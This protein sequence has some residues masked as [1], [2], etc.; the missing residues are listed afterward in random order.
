MDCNI[1]AIR[2]AQ[3]LKRGQERYDAMA[4]REWDDAELSF[5]GAIGCAH[6]DLEATP[7]VVAE[8]LMRE[9]DD[10]VAPLQAHALASTL[11]QGERDLCVPELLAVL[12]GSYDKA[13]LRALYELRAKFERAHIDDIYAGARALLGFQRQQRLALD[14]RGEA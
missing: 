2:E 11:M 14:D 9:C 12:M 7:Y 6:E 10:D 3:A 1:Y 4:E 13:A 8:W 5:D